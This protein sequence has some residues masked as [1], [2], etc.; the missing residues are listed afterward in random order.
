ML[1]QQLLPGDEVL[2]ALGHARDLARAGVRVFLARPATD[3]LGAWVPD[4]GTNGS[5]Y[6]IPRW[7][8][9]RAD[10]DVVDRWRVGMALCAVMDGPVC[11]V[12]VDPRSGGAESA[13]QLQAGDAWPRSYGRQTTP[14]G[15]WHDLVAPLGVH[16]RD[17]VMPG[18]DVKAGDRD[19]GGA[20]F[21]FLCPTVKLSKTTGHV[22][23]YR[24]E[25]PPDLDALAEYAST[26]DSGSTLAARIAALRAPTAAERDDAPHEAWDAMD[27]AGKARVAAWLDGVVRGV[28]EELAEAVAW[29][30]HARDE[31][32]RGWQKL[33][34]DACHRLGRLARADWTPWSVEDAWAHVQDAT[35]L[36]IARAVGL[37]VTWRAQYHRRPPAPWPEAL[38][39]P[40]LGL[41]GGD[42]L[43]RQQMEEACSTS[44]A[45]LDT[46][47]MSP[48]APSSTSST[49]FESST[50]LSTVDTNTSGSTGSSPATPAPESAP[51]EGAPRSLRDLLVSGGS[52][53]LDTP[54]TVPAIWG[55]GAT[56]AW[57][58]GESLIIGGQPGVGK[59]TLAGQVIRGLI[60]GGE[61][62]LDLPVR[63]ARRVLYLAMDRPRQIA[64][65]MRRTLATIPRDDLDER[66][67]VWPGPPPVDV[68]KNTDTF[69]ALAQAAGADI[70]V[71][72]SLKDAAVGLKDDDVAAS[73]NIARQKCISA[74]VNMLELHHTVKRGSNGAAPTSLADFYG[75]TWLAA[76]A[77][78]V[79][80]LHGVAGDPIVEFKHLKTPAEEIGPFRVLHDHDA[81][82]STID[83]AV[84]LV[85]LAGLHRGGLSAKVAAQALFEKENPSR[86]DVEKVRRKLAALEDAGLLERASTGGRGGRAGDGQ[87]RWVPA[88]DPIG[89][90]TGN[91][92]FHETAG[93]AITRP[94]TPET[95]SNHVFHK[96]AGQAITEAITAITESNHAAP[97]T[98]R[99]ARARSREARD[100]SDTGPD[101]VTCKACGEVGVRVLYGKQCAECMGRIDGQPWR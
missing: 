79:I 71:V 7:S 95:E 73:Y 68:A 29:P 17:G 48:S 83:H 61:R 42:S 28:T 64:R 26:D 25:A 74:G 75:S 58:E 38:G 47:S 13:Q 44:T 11:A 98:S 70:V 35:P 53:I 14:S 12:D 2:A 100:A 66:L 27:A 76:G 39:R 40:L 69:L 16:S 62:V 55:E 43:I 92:V 31:R 72:D 10:P 50:V 1:Q 90:I 23:P 81:G 88:P 8:D 33:L 46:P 96:T 15:G 57:A 80:L 94:L 59:T 67:V 89:A 18:I 5:G 54:E 87:A 3:N 101:A 30:E 45:R 41:I 82:T 49:S 56:V 84:D 22:A 32:G 20:G 37:E 36:P 77:G 19:T 93:Q 21:V 78:S 91:H 99:G 34:A 63:R 85:Q 24:W 9:A 60:V 97:P 65:S 51:T 4:G 52:F 86:S 6:I